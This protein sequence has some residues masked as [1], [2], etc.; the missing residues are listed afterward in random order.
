[1]VGGT[2][3]CF[4]AVL[5]C[6]PPLRVPGDTLGTAEVIASRSSRAAAA[7][8][9]L[10]T[11][12]SLALRRRGVTDMGDA[13][14]R[15]SGVNLRDYGGAG[16]LKTVSV[17]GLGAAH[18]MVVYDGLPLAESRAGQTDLGEFS[19]DR[20]AS[21][22]LSVADAPELLCPVRSLGAATL[23]LHSLQPDTARRRRLDAALR[24]GSFATV[25]PSLSASLRQGRTVFGGAADFHYATNDYPYTIANGPLTEERRR[26]GSRMQRWNGEASLRHS[27]RSLGRLLAKV[28]YNDSRQRLPGPVILYT[29]PGDERLREQHGFAQAAWNAERGAWALMA[30]GKYTLRR[31]AYA[32]I[33]D[34]YPDGA[35]RQRYRQREGYMTLG[36]AWHRGAFSAA[37]AADLSLHTLRSNL[38]A[39]SCVRRGGWQ[40]ALSARYRRPRFELTARLL[41]HLAADRVDG[42]TA[43]EDSRLT[44]SFT[45]VWTAAATAD[46][47][48]RLRG[49]YKELFRLPSFTEAYYYHLGEQSLRPELTRQAGGGLTIE[50]RS[51]A[52]RL[53]SLVVTA[54]GYVA[55]V[56]DRIVSVPYN[57][58]IWHTVNLGRVRQSG[59]DLTLAAT[60]VPGRD[61]ALLLAANYSLQRSV[62]H[63]QPGSAGYGRQT[64]YTPR[65]SGAASL[66]YEWRNLGA[67]IHSTFSSERWSTNEHIA[68]TRLPAYAEAGAALYASR[69]VRGVRFTLRADVVNALDRRYEVVRRYPMPGRSYRLTL[70]AGI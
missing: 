2:V 12:D 58:F 61:H 6:R 21:M 41:H 45:G 29:G 24:L 36:A 5:R 39:D 15:F 65:H 33:D 38:A 67:V 23:R 57:L 37:Y 20:I 25:N 43:R 70:T 3:G 14:R 52:A 60:F 13:L 69:T 63:T 35:L 53:R 18:T 10:Q 32:D 47:R 56:S 54:D 17:R 16:G 51:R 62:D 27:F 28:Y 42:G 8:I 64:A 7:A 22:S 55:R 4:V 11:M 26:E 9:P 49:F 19:V 66:A 48:L 44:P 30:A 46:F 68:T 50:C 31:S 59:L 1:M 40:Q 34:Q